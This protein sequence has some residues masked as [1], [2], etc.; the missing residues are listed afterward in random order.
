VARNPSLESGD[1]PFLLC[2][3]F[4]EYQW[5]SPD[6]GY[7]EQI[8]NTAEFHLAICILWSRL[9]TQQASKFTLPDGSIAG[10][11]TEYEIAWALHQSKK[12]RGTPA[13]RIYRNRTLPNFPPEPEDQFQEL[14][15]Q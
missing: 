1:G 4:W 14:V 7:Q 6:Q 15:S 12:T 10:S 8:P 3:Y 2:P 13:L 5:F 9:G 11:G